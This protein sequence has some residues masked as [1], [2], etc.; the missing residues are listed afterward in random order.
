MKNNGKKEERG[1]GEEGALEL[2]A[3]CTLA[4]LGKSR[5]GA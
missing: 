5:T 2:Q 3:L 4:R 1:G